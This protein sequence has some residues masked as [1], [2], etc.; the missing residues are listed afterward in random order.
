MLPKDE[1]TKSLSRKNHYGRN[2]SPKN[3]E[4]LMES[5]NDSNAILEQDISR[6]TLGTELFIPAKNSCS[7]EPFLK[8]SSNLL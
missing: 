8:Q 2:N 6:S 5:Y 3:D 7:N 1:T 4:K